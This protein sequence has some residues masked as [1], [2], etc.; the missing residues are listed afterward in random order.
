MRPICGVKSAET[1]ACIAQKPSKPSPHASVMMAEPLAA[2]A[3]SRT[4]RAI[5]LV[6]GAG[7]RDWCKAEGVK[8]FASHNGQK[9]PFQAQEL[10]TS[11]D[12]VPGPGHAFDFHPSGLPRGKGTRSRKP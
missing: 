10:V 1:F 2:S 9:I 3:V 5:T 4:M 6:P 12:A 7:I 8:T 11:T